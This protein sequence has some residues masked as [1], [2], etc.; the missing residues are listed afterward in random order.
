MGTYGE[1]APLNSKAYILSPMP[2]D[3]IY[4][5]TIAQKL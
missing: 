3:D 5:L 4:S 1:S 2:V